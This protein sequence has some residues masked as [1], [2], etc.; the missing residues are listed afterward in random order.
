VGEGS[1]DLFAPI[2]LF[3]LGGGGKLASF[4]H[5]GPSGLG[6]LF[7]FDALGDQADEVAGGLADGTLEAV[8]HA[9]DAVEGPGDAFE[10][11][12]AGPELSFGVVDELALDSVLGIPGVLEVGDESVEF[13][14]IF[15]GDEDLNDS[16]R[17][18]MG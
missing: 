15:A 8:D 1:L 2:C 9:A 3:A 7:G 11:F 13:S 16:D 14:G 10:V 17:R 12:G 18:A 6:G 4:R 5:F